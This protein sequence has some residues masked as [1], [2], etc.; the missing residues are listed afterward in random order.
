[1]TPQRAALNQLIE[2]TAVSE[3]N[4][5]G[6]IILNDENCV[7]HSV[8]IFHAL[9]RLGYQDLLENDYLGSHIFI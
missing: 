4:R 6:Q 1:M 3:V 7:G 8:A 9:K 5:K 2:K